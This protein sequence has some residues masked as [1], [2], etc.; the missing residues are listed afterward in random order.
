MRR[1]YYNGAPEI[2]KTVL[3]VIVIAS[4]IV[5]G[6]IIFAIIF[7]SENM[8]KSKITAMA[9]DYYE[10]YLYEKMVN[11]DKYKNITDLDAAMEKYRTNGLSPVTLNDLLLYD[12]EKN[13]EHRKYLSEYCDENKTMIKY[14]ME[15][16]YERT[17]YRMEITYSCNF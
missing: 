8:V 1:S 15:P 12:N 11:S 2:K 6:G 13:K 14:Y 17:S 5:V 4:I 10:N 16:P 3:I 7:N 9:E